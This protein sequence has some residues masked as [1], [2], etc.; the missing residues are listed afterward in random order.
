[1]QPI[2]FITLNPGHFH[3]ALVHKEMYEGVDAR[4]HVYAPLGPGLFSHLERLAQFNTRAEAE[5]H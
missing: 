2:R 4:A 3:A 1:M 5:A